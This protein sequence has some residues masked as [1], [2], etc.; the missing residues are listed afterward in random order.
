MPEKHAE[1]LRL[2]R[3]GSEDRMKP[4]GRQEGKSLLRPE[5]VLDSD[6]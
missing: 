5:L 2:Q 1:R 6:S 4:S 3:G